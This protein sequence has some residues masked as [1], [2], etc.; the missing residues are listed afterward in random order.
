M[1]KKLHQEALNLLSEP[2]ATNYG[3]CHACV[4]R[5]LKL[6]P[7]ERLEF[8]SFM[9]ENFSFVPTKKR[10]T[11]VEHLLAKELG[12]SL[13]EE[14][15]KDLE[16]LRTATTKVFPPTEEFAR[17]LLGAMEVHKDAERKAMV[18]WYMIEKD[19]LPYAP[20]IP[21]SGINVLPDDVEKERRANRKNMAML[22]RLLN[23][24]MGNLNFVQ[25]ADMLQNILP[26]KE[27]AKTL[28]LAFFL[29]EYAERISKTASR[30]AIKAFAQL[31]Q[32]D[33]EEEVVPDSSSEVTGRAPPKKGGG[34]AN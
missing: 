30:E 26:E 28:F 5:I 27:P 32:D 19:L 31:N 14:Q 16:I 8:L 29:T 6:N 22:L 34:N 23:F 11:I 15:K 33:P 9:L 24:G 18:L 1:D 20:E 12:D 10:L 2:F 4:E 3:F 17:Y 7:S 21:T 25:I 13:L